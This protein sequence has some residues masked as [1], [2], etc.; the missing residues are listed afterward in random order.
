MS[1][2][3]SASRWERG[4][5]LFGSKNSGPFCSLLHFLL[6]WIYRRTFSIPALLPKATMLL[7]LTSFIWA[8]S[9]QA[10]GPGPLSF[11]FPGSDIHIEYEPTFLLPFFCSAFPACGS[12]IQ[13]YYNSVSTL[14]VST[15]L[16]AF[17]GDVIGNTFYR[18]YFGYSISVQNE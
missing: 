13:Q 11:P 4:V 8:G 5:T 10:L 7:S 12:C 9:I 18:F 17:A 14:V 1:V 3:V 6:I 15:K 2:R 16:P